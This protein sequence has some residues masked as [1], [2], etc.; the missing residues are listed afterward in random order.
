MEQRILNSAKDL[1]FNYGI[2]SITMDDLAKQ[3]GIS[4]KTV[5]LHF[6]DKNEI[7]HKIIGNLIQKHTKEVETC[8]L[9]TKNAIEEVVLQDKILLH[10]FS[11][12]KANVFFE[13]EKYF[14]ATAHE[15]NIHKK[16]CLLKSIKANLERGIE[17]GFYRENL[18]AEIL[19]ESRFHLLNLV[20]NGKSF[21]NPE[22]DLK[23]VLKEL[24]Q[25]YLNGICT[26]KGRKLI[27]TYLNQH[28]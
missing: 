10:L 8:Q 2:K 27:T 6:K 22:F 20:F 1:F 12:I 28:I 9:N 15:V 4:K 11:G 5:Y 18:D 19:S 23:T 17:E 13:L 7:V 3:V 21:P 16:E 14:P 25:L 24:N 26:E